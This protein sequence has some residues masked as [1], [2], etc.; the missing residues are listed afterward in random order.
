MALVSMKT[1]PEDRPDPLGDNPY[2]YGTEIRLNED[3][4]KALGIMAPMAAG[5]V[6]KVEA[7]A[8]VK[9]ATQTVGDDADDTEPEVYMC[10]QITDMGLT[11]T[12]KRSKQDV[13][14]SLYAG[15]ED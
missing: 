4:C 14:K 7:M 8:F 1:K 3:Q 6:V 10:L 13:A 2:G 15:A 5:S 9:S 12:A 11:P